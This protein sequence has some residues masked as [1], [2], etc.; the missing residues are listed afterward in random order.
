[1]KFNDSQSRAVSHFEGPCMVLAG[2]GSGK[3][4][5][6]VNRIKYLTEERD[7][8]PEKIL[9]ITFTRTAAEEMRERF[10]ILAGGEQGITFG[11]F[12]SLFFKILRYAYRYDASNILTEEDRYRFLKDAARSAGLNDELDNEFIAGLSNEISCV[13][14]SG[15]ELKKYKPGVIEKNLFIR[16][17]S[18]FERI[19]R[20]EEKIDFDDM[21]LL[22][23]RLFET[24]PEILDFWRDTYEYILVDEFQD[25][26][27]LQYDLITR[28]ASPKNNIFIVGDDDQS[29][30]SFRGAM[31]DL[32][33]RFEKQYKSDKRF[34]TV[35]LGINYRCSH[36]IVECSLNLISKNK[37]RFKKELRSDKK[38]FLQTSTVRFRTFPEHKKEVTYVINLIEDLNAKGIDYTEM[39]VLF[40]TNAQPGS[41]VSQLKIRNIPFVIRDNIQNIYEHWIAKNIFA[42]MEL[43]GLE[44]GKEAGICDEKDNGTRWRN[45]FLSIANRPVRYIS[46]E[47]MRKE[48]LDFSVLFRENMGKAYVTE[49]LTK[50]K[51]D[52]NMI[53]R[54]NP[55]AAV[56][57]IRK[58]VGYDDFLKK[59]AAER[60]LDI[61]GLMGILEEVEASSA[62]FDTYEAWQE[63]IRE[64]SE[65]LRQRAKDKTKEKESGVSLLTFHSAK[66]TEYDTVFIVDASENYTPYRQAGTAAEIEE[67]RRMFYV[68]LTRAK[69]RL[70]V[71]H[72]DEKFGKKYEVSR[73]VKEAGLIR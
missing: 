71:L 29:I 42:Y 47:T 8:P 54:L 60:S 1:M 70:F 14:N 68:A 57:Y 13:K 32:M 43:A 67:E 25:I 66:G 20:S 3:T 9:V 53:S 56:K 41:F 7:V 73:F 62:E 10:R 38:S 18:E 35:T 27:P 36:E 44:A 72:A 23:H 31:P 39:A 59:Y 52:L 21:L 19:L 11:T 6:I 5:V 24:R 55:K 48:K 28:L 63:H 61:D 40:R 46:R 51:Y 69:N 49:R 26:C 12:H 15:G 65:V 22:T 30:Y 17:I 34:N 64:Y 58:A 2:P 50:L 33:A 45:L 16:I 4:T 37:K